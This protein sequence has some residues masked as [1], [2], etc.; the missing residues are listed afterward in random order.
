MMGDL[1]NIDDLF[2]A[3]LEGKEEAP[4]GKVWNAI[5][6]ELDKN[7][8]ETIRKKYVRMRRASAILLI[9]LLGVS[10]YAVRNTFINNGAK[11]SGQQQTPP[12]ARNQSSKE[13]S[14]TENAGEKTS[15][16]PAIDQD[17]NTLDPNKS[18]ANTSGTSDKSNINSTDRKT[19]ATVEGSGSAGKSVP[20][21]S[22]K[23]KNGAGITS[24]LSGSEKNRN[25]R[26][27]D[28]K[29]ITA[30]GVITSGNSSDKTQITRGNSMDRNVSSKDKGNT[31]QKI[32]NKDFSAG[33]I[34]ASSG[35]THVWFHWVSSFLCVFWFP[36]LCASSLPCV[37]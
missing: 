36:I 33:N 6:Q 31:D 37:S 18:D 30:G 5:E 21:S 8:T 13:K 25:T 2:K 3:G 9:L 35:S 23:N 16:L 17:I 12:P 4:E 11:T 20:Y 34:S 1:H 32:T 10:I 14:T 7:S 29:T 27:R 24:S 22:D 26:D 19:S 15:S 28:A